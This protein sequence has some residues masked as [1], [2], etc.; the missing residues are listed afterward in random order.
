MLAAA[1]V[2]QNVKNVGFRMRKIGF[3]RCG[4]SAAGDERGP[5]ETWP[6]WRWSLQCRK[7]RSIIS[8]GLKSPYRNFISVFTS[9]VDAPTAPLNTVKEFGWAESA[10]EAAR[11]LIT[12]M[13]SS[14]VNDLPEFYKPFPLVTS[15][16]AV[17]EF[18]FNPSTIQRH[19]AFPRATHTVQRAGRQS[20]C[21]RALLGRAGGRNMQELQGVYMFHRLNRS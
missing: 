1:V 10:D 14:P 21:E 5:P 4:V 20:I 9:T 12:H 16:S 18:F 7:W 2:R 13:T 8:V 15:N 6:N 11:S 3:V 17:G 19:S